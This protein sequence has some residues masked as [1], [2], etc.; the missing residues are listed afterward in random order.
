MRFLIY[1]NSRRGAR[2]NNEDRLGYSYSK[3]ALLMVV[4]D[5]MGGHLHG[6][7]AAEIAVQSIIQAFERE[8][9]PK[10]ADPH[11]FLSD[12]ITKAHLAI[13]SLAEARQLAETP[14]TTCVACVVQE[15]A[16]HWA[17]VGDSRLYLIR[18]GL[19]EAVTKDHSRVQ[20]LVDAGRLRPEAML[21]HPDR[22]K[23]FNCLGQLHPPR[24]DISRK[25]T[26]N[27]G[28]TVFLCSDGFWGPLPSA[29][30]VDTLLRKDIHH[31]M[32]ELLDAALERAGNEGDNASIVAMTWQDPARSAGG[33]ATLDLA[34]DRH[35]TRLPLAG[36]NAGMDAHSELT[37][38]DVRRAIDEIRTV[39]E[40]AP[41]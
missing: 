34:G 18:E 2:K 9:Q 13:L 39:A 37:D 35:E 36:V 6:E 19:V 28:D 23:I 25:T 29:L 24:V 1:Q 31:A 22:N 20:L 16:A 8:A 40:K 11:R 14:R 30:V 7:I 4:A 26:L 21:V 33:V 32:P 27:H 41:R 5:G 10:L 38:E 15:G 17:H 3:E 12:T